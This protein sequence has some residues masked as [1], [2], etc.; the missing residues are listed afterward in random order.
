[1]GYIKKFLLHIDG[2]KKLHENL[3]DN[4]SVLYI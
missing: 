3:H 2:N 4:L 1:M